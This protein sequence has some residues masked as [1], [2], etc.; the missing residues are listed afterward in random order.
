MLTA[1]QLDSIPGPVVELYE[2]YM[3]FVI[4]DIARRLVSMDMTSQAAWQM[5]RLI[6]SGAVYEAALDEIATLTRKSSAV[7]K[8]AFE[9]AGVKALH[10]DDEIYRKAGLEPPPLSLSPAMTRIFLIN[11]AR[12]EDTLSN[13]VRTTALAGQQAF[14]EAADMAYMQVTHGVLS[15][16]EAISQA[17]NTVAAK[18]ISTIAYT[19]RMERVD[20]AVRRTVLS[21]T[22]LLVGDLQWARAE[23]MGQDLVQVSAHAGAR[24]SHQ[25]WQGKIYSRS[26]KSTKYPDFRE[27]TGYGTVAGLMGANCR[28]SYYPFFEGI[29]KTAYDEATLTDMSQKTVTVDGKEMSL[30]DAT[31]LQ[32]SM[33]RQIRLYKR[34]IGAREAAGL[35]I[36]EAEQSLQNWQGRVKKLVRE[37][38]LPRQLAREEIVVVS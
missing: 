5:Q 9:N 3:Q 26:G 12:T 13:M 1:A 36:V 7:L 22:N 24:P 6:E 30:Y 20:V 28:H 15:Y 14:V 32:R 19:R 31:Q 4:N 27:S 37:T 38:G 2:R 23:E 21:G 35:D 29:S 18:G 8:K 11:L 16:N 34:Q 33:E 10:F 25:I 17:V